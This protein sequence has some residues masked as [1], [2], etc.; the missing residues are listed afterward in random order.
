M[1]KLEEL[2]TEL[3]GDLSSL[4]V[5]VPSSRGQRSREIPADS[6]KFLLKQQ[7]KVLEGSHGPAS[8]GTPACLMALVPLY[9]LW[10]WYPCMDY[11][12]V[13]LCV[14]VGTTNCL[15]NVAYRH[16]IT[17]TTLSLDVVC[18]LLRKLY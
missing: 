10:L 3:C 9:G 14:H 7:Q 15:M 16:I 1:L 8:T 17:G 4:G 12:S 2:A 18:L 13:L 11:G 5:R 6:I